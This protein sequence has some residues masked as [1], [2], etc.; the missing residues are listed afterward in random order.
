MYSAF[1]GTKGLLK[2]K[3]KIQDPRPDNFVFRLHY[4]F[5]YGILAIACT[6]VTSYQYID[7]SGSAI[8]CM[9]DKGQV[10]GKLLNNYCW[11]MST[12]TLPKH[13]EG[14]IDNDFIHHGVGP[15]VEGDEKIYH[16]Y[17]QWVPLMLAAQAAMF[18]LP[19]WI[20]KQLEGGRFDLIIRGL[21]M[22]D[23][24]KKD[25]KIDDLAKY[26]KERLRDQYDHK[27]WAAKFY[28]CEFLNFVNIVFQICLTDRFLGWSFS[29]YGLAAAGWS[30]IEAEDRVDPMSKVFPRMTKCR[31]DKFGGSGT[32]QNFDAL[33]VLGMNIINEKIY[34]FL[35]FWFVFLAIATGLN[36]IYRVVTLMMP[37]I[38]SKLVILEEY[39]L[40]HTSSQRGGL[41]RILSSMTY[42]D[43]LILYYLAQCMDKKNF[44]QL[45]T[46]MCEKF[47]DDT[48][49]EEE[50]D[51]KALDD[52]TL[53]S[54]VSL[55]NYLPMKKTSNV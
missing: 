29:N 24:D 22:A 43:W 16:A 40:R 11:I 1:K 9:T 14:E 42:P 20:W 37:G 53:K 21:N 7:S 27:M 2:R 31:F 36:L 41:E 33:C 51:E 25:A 47:S 39:G 10:P 32:I 15:D 8:Q 12:F 45:I 50:Q 54:K 49:I 30:S 34:V 28:F 55:K 18:Y 48:H 17:Y 5:T 6:L 3:T 46:K 23:C 26:M 38:R 13:F 35:W 44:N 4:Q 52:S 19:H